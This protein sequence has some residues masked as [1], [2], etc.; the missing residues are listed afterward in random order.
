MR[1]LRRLIVEAINLAV[2]DGLLFLLEFGARRIQAHRLGPMAYEPA[3]YMDRWAAWRNAPDY[4]RGDIR[5]N[6][7]GF[8]RDSDVSLQKPPNTVRIFFLGGSTAYGC[9]GLLPD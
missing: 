9:E 4:D 3:S 2:C 8:R 7:Q 6:H 5:H 1:I